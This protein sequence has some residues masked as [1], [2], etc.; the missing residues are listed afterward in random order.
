MVSL[1]INNW[2][3][4]RFQTPEERDKWIAANDSTFADIVKAA[5]EALH[6]CEVYKLFSL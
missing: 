6:I 2:P 3:T 4:T 5:D 1:W